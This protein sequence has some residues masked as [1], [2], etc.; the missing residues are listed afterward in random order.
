MES[1]CTGNRTVGSNPTLSATS[2]GARP[3]RRPP[4]KPVDDAGRHYGARPCATRSREPRQARKGAAVNGP[5]GAPQDQRAPPY[6]GWRARRRPGPHACPGRTGCRVGRWPGSTARSA[7]PRSSARRPRSGRCPRPRR[8]A[9]SPA[10]TSS[11]GPAGSGR[12]R[13]RASS[14]RRST[15][16]RGRPPTAAASARPA[17][18]SPTHARWTCSSWTPR[19]TPGS[20]TCASCARRRSTRRR[21]TATGS[22]SSTRRTSSRPRPGTAC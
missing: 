22:S 4:P 3:A 10:P 7:S 5:P 15:A 12:R 11:R 16:T 1:V 9:T 14:P 18:R 17:A 6:E 2:S 20:T 19:P 8:G 13:S 21:A